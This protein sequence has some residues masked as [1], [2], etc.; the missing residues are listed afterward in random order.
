MCGEVSDKCT[1]TQRNHHWLQANM[2]IIASFLK[3]VCKR[4]LVSSCHFAVFI[5]IVICFCSLFLS[6]ASIINFNPAIAFCA[7]VNTRTI[8]CL[9]C[10]TTETLLDIIISIPSRLLETTYCLSSQ[11][12]LAYYLCALIKSQIFFFTPH[13]SNLLHLWYNIINIAAL[14]WLRCN[15]DVN[16]VE[17]AVFKTMNNYCYS[18]RH[19]IHC[20]CFSQN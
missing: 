3:G 8:L 7:W 16:T 15:F 5:L 18:F 2:H 20:A 14:L 4:C 17:V 9:Y 11:V 10:K 6:L 13:I 1:C 12:S 19:H